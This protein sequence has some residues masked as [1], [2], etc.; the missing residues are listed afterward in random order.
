M[1]MVYKSARL[2]VAVL[3][4]VEISG[5]ENALL[6]NLLN[7]RDRD[8]EDRR[9]DFENLPF[10]EKHEATSALFRILSARWFK[11]AWCSHELQLAPELVF[12]IP[13]E[14]KIYKLTPESLFELFN[15]TI[16]FYEEN[17]LGSNIENYD[18]LA[19]A[20]NIERGRGDQPYMCQFNDISKLSCSIESDKISIAINVVN[21]QLSYSGVTVSEDEC[22]WILAMIALASG[23]ATV[24]CGIDEPL[25]FSIEFNDSEEIYQ[26]NSW[27]YWNDDNDD[28]MVDFGGAMLQ[29]PSH[30]NEFELKGLGLDLDFM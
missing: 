27:L 18:I 17:D 26:M 13:T 19:R 20:I 29:E 1:D 16:E 14:Q 23:D 9:Q 4:D 15:M 3:E 5:S 8:F 21:L 12:L 22:R 6:Q 28:P 30:I 25:K 11:R 10:A 2:V 7:D 24:L